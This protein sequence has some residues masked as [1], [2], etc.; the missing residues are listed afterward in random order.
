MRLPSKRKHKKIFFYETYTFITFS[1]KIYSYEQTKPVRIYNR[2]SAYVSFGKM[3][4]EEC[5]CMWLMKRSKNVFLFTIVSLLCI[6]TRK[7]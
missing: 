5:N 6:F 4:K 7:V 2:S 1:V 3:L